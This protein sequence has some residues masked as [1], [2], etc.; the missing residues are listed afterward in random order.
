MQLCGGSG[1]T[2]AALAVTFG[3]LSIAEF[4]ALPLTELVAVLRPAAELTDPTPAQSTVTSGERSEVAR[5]I[6]RDLSSR[7]E[8]LIDLGLGYLGL[9]RATPTLSPGETQRLRIATQ[10]RSGLFG[11][12]YV[13]DEPSA[14]LHPADAESLVRVLDDLRAGGN[15]VFVVEH[16][17]DI[18]R[19]ADW[20]VDV[21]PARVRAVVAC[22]TA[23]HRRDS[24]RS[25][26]ASPAATSNRR[27]PPGPPP[28]RAGRHPRDPRRDP[29]QPP[30][31]HDRPRRRDRRGLDLDLPLAS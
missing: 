8:V 9:D 11:V 6:A 3:G 18:V 4:N 28:A 25:R 20:I 26:R 22:S 29:P 21:G 30:R 14:G 24:R 12:V 27:R 17:M 5:S 16:D 19:G 2:R 31:R 23:D 15:S 13:L 7:I 1:L 10:L